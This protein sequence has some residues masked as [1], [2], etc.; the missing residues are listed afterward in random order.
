MTTYQ[1]LIV[2][3]GMA[4]DSAAHGIREIDKDGSI[5]ILSADVDS[6][7][8][9]PALSKKLWTDPEFTWDKTD[10][11]TA[12]DTGAELR[13][14]TEVLS[15]DRDA[16]TVLVGSGQVFGY[17]KLLLVTGLTPSRIDDDGD[18][19]LYFRSARDYQKL[20]ALAQ[21][22]H[23]L[24]IIGGGYIVAELAAALVQQGCEVSLVTPD[25]ILGGS[26]FPAQ[27][28]SEYQKLFADAGVHLV[29]GH[30]VSSVRK[31]ENAEVTLDD[32]IILEADDVV[33]GLGATP[34]TNLAEDAG[35]TVDNGVVVDE[36]LRTDDP[37]IWAA[38]DIA[39]Y[40]DSVL[41]R[42]RVEHVDNATM[43]GKAA[44]RSMAGSDTPYAH[45]P[46]MYSQV[47]GVRWEA[48]GA[49]D[50]SLQTTS[51]EVGDGQV[52]YYLKDGKPVGVLLWNL[53][54]R[55]DEAVKVLADPPE[56]L[57]DAIN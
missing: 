30:R 25:P 37:A 41:G 51:V 14:D 42:T 53:P 50:A 32:G 27:I 18:A 22:G 34:V 28:A 43:M 4:A 8:P 17:Q 48:V 46:M 38:G 15:I 40:P 11:A 5:A 57:S 45:T 6:P 49:L 21:P 2:G 56:D 55:T 31:H 13:L 29:T 54:G 44:G 12:S 52:V 3:G 39:N 24:V 33:A 16:K 19:V 23:H 10:L 20:R 1:Y 26:Q 47:F 36:Y 7:Y 9:R 35:L